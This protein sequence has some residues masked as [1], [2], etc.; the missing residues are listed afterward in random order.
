MNQ[1][2]AQPQPQPQPLC[3]SRSPDHEVVK[4]QHGEQHRGEAQQEEQHVSV[5]VPPA[6]ERHELVPQ[7][8]Q[9]CVQ[10]R[11][12]CCLVAAR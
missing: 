3:G 8:H 1:P 4:H 2:Q 6:L 5:L 10:G 12:G 7:A 9:A 11:A